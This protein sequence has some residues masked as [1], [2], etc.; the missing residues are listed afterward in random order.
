MKNT[1]RIKRWLL[2][3][4][5]PVITAWGG[6]EPTALK[7]LLEQ[8]GAVREIAVLESTKFPEKYL[9]WMEQPL[10]PDNPS[11][12]TFR[13]RVVVGHVGFDRPTVLVTEGY[14]AEYALR[15]GYREELSRLFNTNLVVVEHRYFAGSVPASPPDWRYLTAWNSASDLHRIREI[16]GTFYPG[17]WVATGI[18]KG[19]QA[20]LIY[21]TLFPGDVDIS[22]P[23]VAPLCCGVEDGRHEPFLRQVATPELREKV[24]NFQLELLKRKKTIFPLFREWCRER[25]YRFRIPLEEVY[26]Y[27]M[28]E[29]AF[30]FWQWGVPDDAIPPSESDDSELLDHWMSVSEPAY[31]ARESDYLPFFVQAA[32]ELGYYGYDTAPFEGYLTIGSS[33]GYLHRIMLPR[34]L[35]EVPFDPLLC[36][37]VTAYLEQHDPRMLF[38]YGEYDPWTASGV[39]WLEGKANIRTFIEPGGNHKA[40]ISTLP[41]ELQNEAVRQL[42]EWLERP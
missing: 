5:C 41:E 20:T 17:K 37:T 33:N 12:E 36:D 10:D 23:Y 39:T 34:E 26:D 38:I 24:E 27:C 19:G 13:Q 6:E 32:K 21:Q 4:F 2:L 8:L 25:E 16:L 7:T 9:L 22:V 35:E 42:R 14:G 40:R 18:S 31:F 3:L 15:P 1:I 29:Y 11:G 28:L 30:A